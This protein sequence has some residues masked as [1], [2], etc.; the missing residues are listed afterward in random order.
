MLKKS[1]SIS[2]ARRAG[3]A[4]QGGY[5]R[6]PRPACLARHPAGYPP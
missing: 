4:R 2:S 3:W 5:P 6:Y 1:A